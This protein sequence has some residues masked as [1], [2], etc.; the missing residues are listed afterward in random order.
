ML[1]IFGDWYIDEEGVKLLNEKGAGCEDLSKYSDE[2]WHSFTK[3]IRGLKV[4]QFVNKTTGELRMNVGCLAWD[5]TRVQGLFLG[6]IDENDA[7]VTTLIETGFSRVERSIG[8]LFSFYPWLK[9]YVKFHGEG[10]I[11]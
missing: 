8:N 3:D 1:F 11:L 5:K 6:G 7:R 2:E 10:L 9:K 4:S